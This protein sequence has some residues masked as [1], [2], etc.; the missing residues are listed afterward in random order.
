MPSSQVQLPS[1]IPLQRGDET[2]MSGRYAATMLVL[3]VLLAAAWL[4]VR[5]TKVRAPHLTARRAWITAGRDSAELRV[6]ASQRLSS[7]SMLHVVDYEGRR[8]LIADSVRG[9]QCIVDER[10]SAERQRDGAPD[11]VA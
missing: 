2:W 8:L 3:F 1:V 10:G 7:Q 5:K 4:A 6:V 11:H 9:V